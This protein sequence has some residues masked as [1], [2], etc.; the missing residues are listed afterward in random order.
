[1]ATGERNSTP[2]R[3]GSSRSHWGSS[4]RWRQGVWGAGTHRHRCRAVAAPTATA[5]AAPYDRGTAVA[6][7]LLEQF[8]Q[9][10]G[11]G[12]HDLHTSSS[13]SRMAVLG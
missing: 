8:F 7:H 1:M 4:S 11:F 3:W 10:R 12:F 6:R 2:R 13:A 9:R 5:T